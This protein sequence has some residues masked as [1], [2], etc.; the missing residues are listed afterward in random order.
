MSNISSLCTTQF[1]NCTGDAGNSWISTHLTNS[2]FEQLNSTIA[3][4]HTLLEHTYLRSGD[5]F[6][7][8]DMSVLITAKKGTRPIKNHA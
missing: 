4:I 2:C 6:N 5:A 1:S 7:L 3:K 8:T